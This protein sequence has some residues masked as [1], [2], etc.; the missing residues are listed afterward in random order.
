MDFVRLGIIGLGNMGSGHI[1]NYLAG[2]L[3]NVKIT[4][5]Q[6]EGDGEES[7]RT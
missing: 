1:G 7:F 3:K 6:K 5:I 2:H 4:G